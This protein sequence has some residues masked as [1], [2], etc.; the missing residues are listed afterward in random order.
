MSLQ[1]TKDFFNKAI[2]VTK[3]KA[4]KPFIDLIL[5]KTMSRKLQVFGVACVAL[6][7]DK[8][9]DKIWFGVAGL[10]LFGLIF[11]NYYKEMTQRREQEFGFRNFKSH[12]KDN[13][14]IDTK[15]IP[16]ED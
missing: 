8:I 12:K 1:A 14:P 10:Y 7:M 6:F 3:E 9:S 16:E 4:T 2:D 11:M 15:E 13:E 5:G